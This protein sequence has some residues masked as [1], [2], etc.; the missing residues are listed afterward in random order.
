MASHHFEYC[1][2]QFG[3]RRVPPTVAGCTVLQ[4]AWSCCYQA[5]QH[6]YSSAVPSIIAVYF[7]V[8]TH[9]MKWLRNCTNKSKSVEPEGSLHAANKSL[10]QLTT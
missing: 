7:C 9:Q 5:V 2:R 10:G 3:W 1:G 8:H 6:Q 4:S